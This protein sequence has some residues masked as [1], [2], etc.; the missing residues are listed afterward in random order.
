M[1]IGIVGLG[2]L[3]LPVALAIETMGHEVHGYDINPAVAGYVRDGKIPYEEVGVEDLLGFT[4]L[5]VHDTLAELVAQDLD[6]IFV[7]VQT[8]HDPRYEGVTTLP[9]ERVDF[10]YT[11]LRQACAAVST[12]LTTPTVV[13][14]ISTV[15]P[16]TIE[17]EIKPL[18]GDNFRLVYTPQFIAMGTV[19]ENFLHPEFA[20]IGVDDEE[21]AAV[22]T[23]FFSALD[24]GHVLTDVRTA[25]G[26][27]VFYN[28]FITAKTVLANIYGELSEKLGMN[29]DDIYTALTAADRRLMSGAYLKAG[30]G[31]GGGCHPRDNIALS[32]LAREHDLSFDIFEALML[33]RENH[34]NWIAEE[35]WQEAQV[36]PQDPVYVFGKSFKPGTNITTGSPARLLVNLLRA[37]FGIEPIV[38]DPHAGGDNPLERHRLEMGVYVIA[39]DHGDWPL[40]PSG[41]VV[42]DPFG[43]FP[44]H[45]GVTVR[46]LGRK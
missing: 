5:V 30:V 26:I 34:M 4:G 19:V 1:R 18:I 10:D 6:I 21:A 24:C 32:W 15:L 29:V 36:R 45:A 42:I 25:E 14:V 35:V 2:K 17:R 7:A 23:E 3:G 40:P 37:N 12:E 33:A 13:A 28:T 39:T 31:D 38:Y 27:K 11:Y 41:S 9:D 46:R 43:S 20:L 8:P 16:G 44:D 22:M